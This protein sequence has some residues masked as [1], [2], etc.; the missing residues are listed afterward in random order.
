MRKPK[1]KPIIDKI[2]KAFRGLRGRQVAYD[3]NIDKY[4]QLSSLAYKPISDRD[5][6][7]SEA[8]KLGYTLDHD[9]ST[10]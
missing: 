7:S 2:G 10:R 6:I 8:A 1:I 3:G 4:K 5:S 9:L